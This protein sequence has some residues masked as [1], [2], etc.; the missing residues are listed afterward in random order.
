MNSVGIH[1]LRISFPKKV[2]ADVSEFCSKIWGDFD[3]DGFGLWS[4][5]SRMRWSSGISLNFDEDEERSFRVHCN[6]ITLDC[7][8][9]ACDELSVPDL[10]L[11]IEYFDA[12]G[13]KCTRIDVYFD[14]YDRRVFPKD[15]DE[16]IKRND[17]SGLRHAAPRHK[18]DGGIMIRE[19]VA[20]GER[21]SR[22]NGKYIRFYNKE[23]ESDG[24]RKCNRFEVEF[25]GKKAENVFCILARCEGKASVFATLCGSLVAGSISFV[26]RTGDKNISR[27]ERYEWWEEIVELLGGEIQI[28]VERK[29]DTLTGKIDWVKRGVAPSLACLKKIFVDK[30]AFFRWLWDICAEGDGRMNAATRQIAKENEATMDYRWG[31]QISKGVF[32]HVMS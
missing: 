19:E 24:E 13:G 18:W 32:E 20:F 6:R 22:G 15:L 3:C 30:D 21:G 31:E 23:L 29:K 28:R 1:W 4:Y 11:L 25:T 2:L 8:G 27:L 16:L 17:Y 7:P 12:L 26:K 5:D 10:L 14:D 9:S